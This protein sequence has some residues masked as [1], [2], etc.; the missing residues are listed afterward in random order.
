[1]SKSTGTTSLKLMSSTIL[2]LSTA[3]IM[4]ACSPAST[5]T[6][7]QAS[8]TASKTQAKNVIIFIG[9]GMG[10]ST[11][12]A[13]RIFDG[14][15]QGKNG[16]EHELAFESFENV[17]LVKTYNT[18]AQVPDSAGTATAILSGYKTNIGAVN[19]PP[20]LLAARSPDSCNPD[21]L[22]PTLTKRAQ[23]TGKAVGIIST[24]RIT[25]AT[26]AA[27]Y[28][29]APL[30]DLEAD[31]DIQGIFQGCTSI[32][33]QMVNS[34]AEVILGGGSKEFSEAQMETL[35]TDF[36]YAGNKTEMMTRGSCSPR[37]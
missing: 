2:G 21:A 23:G 32:A 3:L 9:D 18:N 4:S 25:H 17:A 36:I 24:A 30:R 12:T 27:M 16:E 8:E 1:M 33:Q 6:A 7:D 13:A 11:I 14:Q 15:S 22:P 26:P 37:H 19:V 5:N 34:Q 20:A 10:I 31:K 29:H 28:S 35:K